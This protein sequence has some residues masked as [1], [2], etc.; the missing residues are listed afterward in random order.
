MDCSWLGCTCWMTS[1]GVARENDFARFHMCMCLR[2]R[3]TERQ[4]K[5]ADRDSGVRSG[6]NN[7]KCDRE[8]RAACL[9]F[10]WL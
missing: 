6:T 3:D 4:G 7:R 9:T 5:G 2:E 8:S 10:P 1:P